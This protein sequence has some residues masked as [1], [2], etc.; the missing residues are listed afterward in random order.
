[1]LT[2]YL[3]LAADTMLFGNPLSDWAAA[4]GLGFAS[5]LALVFA[6]RVLKRRVGRFAGRELPQG[7]R[8]LL[9]L[10]GA[11]RL[12]P[13]FA[14]SLLVGSKYLDLG[15][16][17]ERATTATMIVTVGLQVGIWLS[18]AVRFYLGEHYARS[19]DRNSQT[20]ITIAQFVASLA[21]WS[22]VVLIAL[23]NLG[24][25]VKALLTGLGIG[26]IAVAL[27][28]QNVLGDLLASLSIALD[29]PFGIG[30][31]LTLDTGYAGTV[32]AI[33]IRSTRLRSITGEQIVLANAEL[34]KARIR[35][36]GRVS[37]RRTVFRFGLAHGSPAAALREVPGLVRAAVVAQPLAR[38]ERAH[39][40]G[41]TATAIEFEI[42]YS[43]GSADYLSFLDT[44]QA[45][46]LTLATEFERRG[47]E[48]AS[49]TP[50]VH[51]AH[52]AATA[53]SAG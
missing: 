24:F 6:R 51:A 49:L 46:N 41:F 38:F 16:R 36:Y 30:D 44:Q 4:L 32:E 21:I 53:S 5:F 9:S 45:V 28:V 12:L 31:A 29:K 27:A 20:M 23:D 11:T 3:G 37:E 13:L 1:M 26:G 42:V 47:I 34:V 2:R 40:I 43:V 15:A 33:G 10:L 50:A 22:L 52:G 25:Q 35:N 14:V 17:A 39:L 48:F 18:A 19:Q 7:V 8:L